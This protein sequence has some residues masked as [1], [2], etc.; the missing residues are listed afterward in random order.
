MIISE[1]DK[2]RFLNMVCPEYRKLAEDLI[3]EKIDALYVVYG[4]HSYEHSYEWHPY[5]VKKCCC[6]SGQIFMKIYEDT[7]EHTP[8]IILFNLN[9]HLRS[10][11]DGD[12]EL[13]RQV[14]RRYGDQM[15]Y[16]FLIK[17]DTD[18]NLRW[19]IMKKYMNDSESCSVIMKKKCQK[20]YESLSDS[21]KLLLELGEDL[22]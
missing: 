11:T 18:I 8:K 9:V 19:K 22:S 16:Y 20:I 15:E 3:D 4:W 10:I 14:T 2:R 13:I 7:L 12:I 6:D 5:G 1:E 21:D 17:S